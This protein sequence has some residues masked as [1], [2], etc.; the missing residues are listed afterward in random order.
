[1]LAIRIAAGTAGNAAGSIALAELGAAFD[2]TGFGAELRVI[3]SR[4]QAAPSDLTSNRGE[5]VLSARGTIGRILRRIGDAAS[6]AAVGI[7]D[8]DASNFVHGYIVEVQQ[9]TARIAA[10]LVPDAPTLHGIRGGS[11]GCGP[12]VATVVGD[13]DVEMPDAAGVRGV[14]V[15]GGLGRPGHERE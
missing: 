1:M 15:T 8:Q 13:G 5:G 10:A 3:K 7:A 11:V 6:G 4:T 2:L 12:S 14:R 9:V